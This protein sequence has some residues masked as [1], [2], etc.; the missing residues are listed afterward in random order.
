MF[1]SFRSSVLGFC[2][3]LTTYALA[4]SPGGYATNLRAWYKANSSAYRDGG[5]TLCTNG[6]TV[7]QWNDRSGNNLN[8]TQSSSSHRPTW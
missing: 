3:T 5:S 2:V 1:R 4:Q 7:R 8:M 6:Q